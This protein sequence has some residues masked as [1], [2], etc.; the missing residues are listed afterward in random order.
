MSDVEQSDHGELQ[1]RP[2]KSQIMAALDR[3]DL[4]STFHLLVGKPDSAQQMFGRRILVDV[5]AMQDLHGRMLEKLANHRVDGLVAT[6]DVSFDDKSSLQFG[7]WAEFEQH[8]WTGPKVTNEVRLRWEFLLSVDAYQVPQR[9]AVTVKLSPSLKPF[10][11]MRAVFSKDLSEIDT[12]EIDNAPI[13][14]RVDFVNH[15]LSKELIAVVD[16]WVGGLPQPGVAHSWFS[17]FEKH[18]ESFIA[19]L[20]YSAPII[21]ALAVFM[22]LSLVFGDIPDTNAPIALSE[23]LILARWALVSIIF[24]YVVDKTSNLISKRAYEAIQRYG[25]F[26]MFQLTN[27]DH[28]SAQK[29]AERNRGQIKKCIL[30]ASFSLAL[31]IA[32]GIIVYYGWS[33]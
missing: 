6:V 15:L 23:S 33:A 31:N 13:L 16:E 18:D 3:N 7:T 20:R 5:Q 8:R 11:V 1:P 28:T 17:W 2:E 27:G 22:S 10:D 12:I 32:A 26:R 29:L 21:A 25:G 30:N 14:C 24:I 9:H 19:T 4:R